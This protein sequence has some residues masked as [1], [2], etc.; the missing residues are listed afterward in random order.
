MITAKRLREL[1]A[2]ADDE[3]RVTIEDGEYG[4]D[5]CLLIR[6]GM[7]EARIEVGHFN[8]PDYSNP[9]SPPETAAAKTT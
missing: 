2:G 9:T 7:G 3:A 1:L 8:F 4:F 5:A 6:D